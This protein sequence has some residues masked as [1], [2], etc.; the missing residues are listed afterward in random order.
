MPA[1][2]RGQASNCSNPILDIFTKVSGISTD[3]A[4]L[5][6]VI[7]EE[8]TTPGTPIQVF[9]PAGRQTVDLND[10]PVGQKIATGRYVALY[11][12]ELTEPIG[13]HIIQ[14]YFKLTPTSPEQSFSEE[15]EILAEVTAGSSSGYCTVGDLRDAGVTIS[16]ADDARLQKLITLASRMIDKYTGRFFEPRTKTI[17]LDGTGARGLLLN[18]PIIS[19]SEVK[20]VSDETVS[21]SSVSL[22]DLRIYNRHIS[23]N[24]LSPDDRESP[25]IEFLEF[26]YRNESLS[27]FSS[28]YAHEI[29]HPHRW[30]KGTQNVEITG[31]FGYTDP[32]GTPMG[33]TPDGICMACQLMVIRLFLEP[34]GDGN[35]DAANS[36]RVTEHK[37]RDQSIK[38][39]DPSSLGSAG[40]GAFT[41]DPQIDRILAMYSRGPLMGST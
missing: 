6:F 10:C 25:K 31:I 29:F 12:P 20:L 4:V 32:D 8:V 3:V 23:Q 22:T 38:F 18:E 41:G 30:P 28:S 14:W 9:P 34:F 35:G 1:L 7:F 24:L 39:A 40:V 33:Q 26:D 21:T 2:A 37:T 11:T 36:W 13:T 27:T 16:Q 5:Q 17:R 19:I 15:F